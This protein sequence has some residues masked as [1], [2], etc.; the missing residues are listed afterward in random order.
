MSTLSS[1]FKPSSYS[2]LSTFSEVFR[3]RFVGVNH[4]GPLDQLQKFKHGRQDRCHW[5]L[6]N[7]AL[8]RGSLLNARVHEVSCQAAPK[9]PLAPIGRRI[10]KILTNTWLNPILLQQ[11]ERRGILTTQIVPYGPSHLSLHHLNKDK[12]PTEK[13]VR[14]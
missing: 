11:G 14:M 12:K 2:R 4:D 9:Q 13:R 10:L 6:S 3:E 5:P 8:W 1:T 7:P